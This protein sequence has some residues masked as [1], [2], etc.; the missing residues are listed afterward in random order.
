METDNGE[1]T[2]K[3]RNFILLEDFKIAIKYIN[4]QQTGFHESNIKAVFLHE[5]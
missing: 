1:Q 4:S 2:I 5:G 3:Y